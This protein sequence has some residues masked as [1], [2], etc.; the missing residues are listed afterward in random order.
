MNEYITVK[1]S[2]GEDIA[3]R[4]QKLIDDNP[5]R[6]LFF[7]D[8]E[9][10]I[11]K[12]ILTSSDPK[13]SVSLKLSDFAVITA[14]D[15]WTCDEA[16]IRL[17]SKDGINNVTTPGSNYGIEG[18]IID[19][20]GIA[21]AI[22]IDGGRETYI[23]NLSIKNTVCGI[24]IKYGANSGSSDS[25]ILN[26]NIIGNNTKQSVGMLIEGFDNTFT[27]IRIGHVFIGVEIRS[28]G[29]MLRNI[30]PLY[31]IS[32][33]DCPDYE[34]SIGFNIVTDSMHNWFD[35]CYS[36]QFATGFKTAGA[37]IFVNCFCYWYSG[38]EKKH[39]AFETAEPFCGQIKGLM[40]GGAEPLDGTKQ[41]FKEFILSQEAVIRDV[42][43]DQ[44]RQ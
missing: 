2:P 4:L 35:Y 42:Y 37:G 27:N 40:I 30:H 13:K 1:Q 38:K 19:C 15:S 8:G 20:R 17:G 25:D 23:R 10:K 32:P 11:G 39:V 34:E 24:H 33:L 16:M 9:Y 43:I 7:P 29:N 3:D 18:G 28:P 36:D 26:V 14:A 44:T 5:N 41:F 12:P 21:K 31:N 6:V 22:S